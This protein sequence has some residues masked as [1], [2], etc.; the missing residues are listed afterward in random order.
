MKTVKKLKADFFIG[1]GF[2]LFGLLNTLVVIPKT[3]RV[4][5][6]PLMVNLEI[7]QNGRVLPYIYS[8][9]IALCGVAL[10][11]SQ[12]L[13]KQTEP[14]AKEPTKLAELREE[15]IPSSIYLAIVILFAILVPLIHFIPVAIICTFALTWL[16]G[17]K[18]LYV[19]IPV[20]VLLPV[21]VYFLLTK[22]LYVRF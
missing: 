10:I 18:K 12:L 17:Y 4:V 19:T 8:G 1:T 15:G 3:I 20:S 11:L 2:L 21:A 5:K 6:N 9:L 22:L 7:V 14:E 16:Y 13:K